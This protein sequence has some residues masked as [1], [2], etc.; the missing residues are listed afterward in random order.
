KIVH[1][2]LEL[3]RYQFRFPRERVE[4]IYCAARLAPEKGHEFLIQAMRILKENNYE[5]EARLV[6]DGPS[7]QTLERM[8]RDL[9]VL[10]R[11]QFLGYLDEDSQMRE[12][13]TSDLCVLPSLAEGLPVS[14]TEALAVGVPVIATNIAGISELIEDGKTG[15]LVRP[16]DPVALA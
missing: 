16:S 13:Y 14:L 1:C 2:G 15:L 7:R 4:K 5:L 3:G 11:I 9:E 8:A 12:L 6:G 10:D